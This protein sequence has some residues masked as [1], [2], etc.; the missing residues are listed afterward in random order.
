M[1]PRDRS[2]SNGDKQVL[3]APLFRVLCERV[4]ARIRMPVPQVRVRSVNANLGCGTVERTRRVRDELDFGCPTLSR[5][6]RKGGSPRQNSWA[7][8]ISP[9]E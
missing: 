6:L 4:G 7:T 3:G 9:E 8:K 5:S 2:R 1:T